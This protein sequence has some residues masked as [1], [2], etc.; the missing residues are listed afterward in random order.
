MAVGRCIGKADDHGNKPATE[1]R[2]RSA[3]DF[4]KGLAIDRT[5]KQEA[6]WIPVRRIVGGGQPQG[7]DH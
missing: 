7:P 2:N 5:R 4:G 6:G 1:P 3:C